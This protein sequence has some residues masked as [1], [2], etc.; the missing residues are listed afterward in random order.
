M[1]L[2]HQ[3]LVR[4]QFCGTLLQQAFFFLTYLVSDGYQYIYTQLKHPNKNESAIELAAQE[5]ALI[6]AE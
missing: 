1:G 5:S 4:K 3:R 2:V 6:L